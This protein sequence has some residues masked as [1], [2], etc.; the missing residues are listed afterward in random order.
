V[1]LLCLVLLLHRVRVC[2]PACVALL[3]ATLE[4][5][6]Y[7]DL[8]LHTWQP[9]STPASRSTI[10]G[11]DPPSDLSPDLDLENVCLGLNP[12]LTSRIR[13]PEFSGDNL[14]RTKLPGE[15]CG[16]FTRYALQNWSTF[17]PPILSLL[18]VQSSRSNGH[19]GFRGPCSP[20][21]CSS[22][23]GRSPVGG[24]PPNHRLGSLDPGT[25]YLF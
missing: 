17:R 10:L 20:R 6:R 9:F 18:K 2:K 21:I 8:C 3:V 23:I 19:P 7:L 22:R 14:P 12:A 5:V 11:F 24:T 25:S 4:R 16:R 15:V 13:H 1:C